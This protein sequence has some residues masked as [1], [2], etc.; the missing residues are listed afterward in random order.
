MNARPS[1]CPTTDAIS[2]NRGALA[3]AIAASAVGLTASPRVQPILWVLLSGAVL[4]ALRWLLSSDGRRTG[5]IWLPAAI[6]LVVVASVGLRATQDLAGLQEPL[7]SSVDGEAELGSDPERRQHGVTAELVVQGRRWF[8]DFGRETESAVAGLRSGDRL[9]I[10]AT[11]REFTDAPPGWVRSRHLAGRLQVVAAEAMEGTRI[12]F[13]SANGVHELLDRGASSMSDEHRALYLGL[14][15][16]DDRGQDDLTRFHFRASGLSH[17]LAVSGQNMVFVLAVLSPLLSRMTFR[18]RWFAGASAIAGFVLITRAEPSVLRAAVMAV[19]ALTAMSMGRVTSGV[20][21]LA[22]TVSVLL[23]A[24]P[25]LVHSVGFRLS[26]AATAGLVLFARPLAS[27]LRGP[28]WVTNPL[29]VTVAA[30]FGAVPVMVA[31]FGPVSVLSVPANLAAE[32]AAGLVMTSGLTAGLAAGIVREELAWV[33]QAPGRVAVWWVDAVAE[34][35]SG[36]SLPPVGLVGWV[37]ILAGCALSVATLKRFGARMLGR[38]AMAAVVPAVVLLRPPF[39]GPQEVRQLD[40]PV[41]LIAC[42]GEWIAS[43]TEKVDDRIAADVTEALWQ[44]GLARVAVLVAPV[45][46]P[47]LANLA[48]ALDARVVALEGIPTGPLARGPPCRF[49][50]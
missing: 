40:G 15:V 4:S 27:W 21:I 39:P 44:V 26:V 13:T 18:W 47:A 37:A 36:L 19:L 38:A 46:N 43:V 24:D 35:V 34:A 14:V 7:P 12:W 30:Q 32:P 23:V 16:G 5:S 41:E 48:D 45:D 50:T 20:R 28:E 8:A 42:P 9:E 1:S 3:V 10:S 49:S 25:M 2:D 17:L 29:A 11:V 6:G 31:T 33:L 22:I